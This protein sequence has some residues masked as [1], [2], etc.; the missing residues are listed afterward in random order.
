M[1]ILGSD[2][3]FKCGPGVLQES[4][5]F[6]IF[7]AIKVEKLPAMLNH[8]GNSTCLVASHLQDW[9]NSMEYTTMLAMFAADTFMS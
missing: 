3:F 1:I 4:L 7:R 2:E 9:W 8:S 6:H 5:R